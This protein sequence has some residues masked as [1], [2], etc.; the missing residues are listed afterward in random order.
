[1]HFAVHSGKTADNK[2]QRYLIRIPKDRM[3]AT[4]IWYYQAM[5]KVIHRCMREA[6]G[7]CTLRETC[8]LGFRKTI[9]RQTKSD[10]PAGWC[11]GVPG[12]SP[13]C[14]VD[15]NAE[16]AVIFFQE[17]KQIFHDRLLLAVPKYEWAAFR[18]LPSKSGST[19]RAYGRQLPVS[20]LFSGPFFRF[21]R[22]WG[23]FLLSL[24]MAL[25]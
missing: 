19:D 16:G 23:D 6:S 12:W 25:S 24:S 21:N 4:M 8:R 7:K 14:S 5:Q 20:F 10:A 13:T 11:R 1:M 18:N 15:V 22:C 9:S 3:I 2:I 17:G